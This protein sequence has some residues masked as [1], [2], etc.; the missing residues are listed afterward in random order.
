M[1][2]NGSVSRFMA[3]VS[4][5]IR[6]WVMFRGNEWISFEVVIVEIIVNVRIPDILDPPFVSIRGKWW[7]WPS[8]QRGRTRLLP[9]FLWH[10]VSGVFFQA[11]ELF[12]ILTVLTGLLGSYNHLQ[13]ERIFIY[14]KHL[15]WDYY[16]NLLGLPHIT[17]EWRNL[18]D[19]INRWPLRLWVVNRSPS[20]PTCT[21]YIPTSLM[22][23]ICIPEYS[24][25]SLHLRIRDTCLQSEKHL[26]E[27]ERRGRSRGDLSYLDFDD[28][29]YRG[30]R[31]VLFEVGFSCSWAGEGS[32]LSY[33][34]LY[35]GFLYSPQGIIPAEA[36]KTM[37]REFLFSSDLFA[38]FLNWS[39]H[40]LFIS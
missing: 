14:Q 1:E 39:Q 37:T 10:L 12:A 30:S 31:V 33:N 9:W 5:C 38:S 16:S 17:R 8:W 34:L 2:W 40:Y 7:V 36:S 35:R 27:N 18:A 26:R 20:K 29:Y 22:E 28:R 21:R 19:K 32:S 11:R 24:D 15:L 3:R 4:C 25:R 6:L 23:A 13:V